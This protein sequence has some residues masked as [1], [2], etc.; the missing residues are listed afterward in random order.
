MTASRLRAGGEGACRFCR[1]GGRGD[2]SC[3]LASVS[4][5]ASARAEPGGAMHFAS[6]QWQQCV[7]CVPRCSGRV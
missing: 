4:K 7:G 3:G 1:C 5:S 2:P 6:G